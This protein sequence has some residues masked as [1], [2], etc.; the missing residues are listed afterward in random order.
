[1]TSRGN[2]IENEMEVVVTMKGEGEK[3]KHEKRVSMMKETKIEQWILM[4]HEKAKE[5]VWSPSEI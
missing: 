3:L 5:C 2:E 4:G 1:M